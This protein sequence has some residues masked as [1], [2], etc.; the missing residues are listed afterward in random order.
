MDLK[1]LLRQI[2]RIDGFYN[3]LKT[4]E[5]ELIET[6]DS[7]KK[8]IERDTKVSAV[9]KH[10]L[11]TMVKSEISRMAGLITY[12]LKTIFDDQNLTFVPEVKTKTNKIYIDFKTL[13]EDIETDFKSSGGSISITEDFLIRILCILKKNLARLILLDETFSAIGDEYIPNTGKFV[14]ELSKKINIDVLLVTHKKEFK[15]YADH[16]YRVIEFK[17]GLIMEK[18]K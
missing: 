1:E 7:L 16:A 15:H 8:E 3:A 9:L 11:D 10:L 13:N 2:D 6:I 14:N 18:I 4:R 17:K 5:K 12:G